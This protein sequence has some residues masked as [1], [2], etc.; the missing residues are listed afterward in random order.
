MDAKP[1]SNEELDN[2]SR[3]IGES[4][5]GTE[6]LLARML[7]TINDMN[8]R[9]AENDKKWGQRCIDIRKEKL[10]W[11][12]RAQEVETERDTLKTIALE[13]AKQLSTFRATMPGLCSAKSM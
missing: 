6:R 11:Q 10:A 3:S 2:V 4:P 1:L 12:K 9:I 7:A 5:C 13:Q 8:T